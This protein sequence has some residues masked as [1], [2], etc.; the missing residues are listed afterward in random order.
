MK[1]FKLLAIRPLKNPSKRFLKMLEPNQFYTFYKGVD[2]IKVE[3]DRPETLHIRVN[4]AVPDNFHANTAEKG[5]PGINISAIVGKNG[6]GKSSLIEMLFAAV[7]N[8]ALEKKII[9]RHQKLRYAGDLSVEIYY[10]VDQIIHCMRTISGKADK[11][12]TTDTSNTQIYCYKAQKDGEFQFSQKIV[13]SSKLIHDHFFYTIAVNY[14]IY[15]LNCDELGKWIEPLFHK[16]DGYQTPLVINP[17]RNSGNINIQTENDLVRQRMLANLLEPVPDPNQLDHTLRNLAKGKNAIWLSLKVNDKKLE[18]YHKKNKLG[19]SIGMEPVYEL[20]K[21]YTGYDLRN[22]EDEPELAA[23]KVYIQYKLIRICRNYSRYRRFLKDQQLQDLEGFIAKIIKDES[24]V[25]Y[26][27]KQALNFLRHKLYVHKR[28][29]N[30]NKI[31]IQEFSA[32]IQ[33]I[34]NT[35]KKEHNRT[36]HTI[37]LIPP[38][39]FDIKIMFDDTHGF[40]DFSSGEK[41]KIHSISSVVYHLLNVNSVFKSGETETSKLV[42]NVY[43][44]VNIIFDEIELYFHP[45]LQRTF[46]HDLLDYIGKINREHMDHI[47]GINILFSTHSPFILSDIPGE[48]VL[49]L[50]SPQDQDLPPISQS[51]TFGANIHDLLAH[52]FF[53]R[54]GFMGEWAKEKIRSAINYMETYHTKPQNNDWDR[55]SLKKFIALLGEPMIKKSMFDLYYATFGASEIDREIERLIRLKAQIK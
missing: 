45:D 48:N 41:Q 4:T 29:S 38:S 20:L 47:A 10:Q 7:H 5:S 16:N 22:V 11:D 3:D 50:R 34:I 52:E 44:N 9:Y 37:E 55:L 31:D 51:E 33:D 19:A 25:T 23:T 15:G 49:Y 18:A 27:I 26:K 14:S 24:H 13:R 42:Q 30:I 28:K 2:F 40:D 1:N 46:V 6:S 8:F 32:Y 21:A 53:M 54:E 39:I 43:E 17:F 36:L 35:E 12:G